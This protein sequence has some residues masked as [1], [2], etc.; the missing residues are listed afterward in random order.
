MSGL[1]LFNERWEPVVFV[2]L[3][4]FPPSLSYP[5]CPSLYIF[6]VSSLDIFFFLWVTKKCWPFNASFIHAHT[7]NT[8]QDLTFPH[9]W[10]VHPSVGGYVLTKQP[11]FL[12]LLLLFPL[13]CWWVFFCLC[14]FLTHALISFSLRAQA[15]MSKLFYVNSRNIWMHCS[16][17]FFFLTATQQI[18]HK[19]SISRT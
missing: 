12:L 18:Q 19:T 4:S 5:R 9:P 14:F 10:G 17:F 7:R 16:L 13:L 8:L 2:L 11:S 6:S 15:Q 3:P 1:N